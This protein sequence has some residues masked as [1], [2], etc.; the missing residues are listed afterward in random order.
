MTAA[1][2]V[3]LDAGA[4]VDARAPEND[5]GSTALEAAVARGNVAAVR[6]LLERGAD[7]FAVASSKMERA[8]KSSDIFD[9]YAQVVRLMREAQEAQPPREPHA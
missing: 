8:E 4:A 5:N 7:P 3:L 2:R 9:S 1:M 6:L